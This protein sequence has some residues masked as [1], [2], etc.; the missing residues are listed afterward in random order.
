MRKT[1][2]YECMTIIKVIRD[3]LPNWCPHS[4]T[5]ICSSLSLSLFFRDSLNAVT[6]NSTANT[7]ISNKSCGVTCRQNKFSAGPINSR[8]VMLL[9]NTQTEHKYRHDNGFYEF[10]TNSSATIPIQTH[11]RCCCCCCCDLVCSL[12]IP[13]PLLEHR[14]RPPIRSSHTAINHRDDWRD[15]RMDASTCH[16][17]LPSSTGRLF[18]RTMTTTPQQESDMVLFSPD[19]ALEFILACHSRAHHHGRLNPPRPLASK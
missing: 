2:E 10:L 16:R 4:V 5:C 1:N 14:V 9:C 11:L 3:S 12:G 13:C 15:G 17:S 19:D 8:N 18:L 6:L 7:C